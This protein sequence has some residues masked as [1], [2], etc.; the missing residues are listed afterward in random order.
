MLIKSPRR[1]RRRVT[2][3]RR[4]AT[5]HRG[6]R[7]GG[8]A[9]DVPPEKPIQIHMSSDDGFDPDV[10]MIGDSDAMPVPA[11]Q[12]P[13]PVYGNFRT[14]TVSSCTYLNTTHLSCHAA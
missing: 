11:V 7:H 13:P 6:K 4:H 2:H 10:E 3:G 1:T 12:H 9:D 5:P 14:S 8:P